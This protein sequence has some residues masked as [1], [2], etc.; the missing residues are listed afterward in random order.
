MENRLDN[1][2]VPP[3]AYDYRSQDFCYNVMFK[4]LAPTPGSNKTLTTTTT[5]VLQQNQN[6]RKRP[7]RKKKMKKLI[8]EKVT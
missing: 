6:T 7:R 3:D 5:P 2:I 8:D 1:R 4:N